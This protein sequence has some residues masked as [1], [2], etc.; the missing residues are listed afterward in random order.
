MTLGLKRGCVKLMLH[1][2]E[3]YVI[4]QDT[5]EILFDI[6]G[7]S[8]V[9]IQHIGSTAI[10]NIMAKPI[11]DIAVGVRQFEDIEPYIT[12]LREKGIIFRGDDNEGKLFVIGDFEKDTRTHHI[13][14][15]EH[16]SDAW[17]NYI[18]FRDYLNGHP[19]KAKEYEELKQ[20]LA[21]LYHEDRVAYTKGKQKF[22]DEIHALAESFYE[23]QI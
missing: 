13:H 6:L 23:E 12:S 7:Q 9:G 10:R 20:E 5:I 14:V 11:I 1:Q 2:E 8:A 17:K 18:N 3:W 4:A 22:I 19:A 21:Q 15:V 16:N